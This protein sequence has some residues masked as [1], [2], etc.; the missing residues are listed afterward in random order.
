[1]YRVLQK[2]YEA[3][4]GEKFVIAVGDCA[5]NGGMFKDSYYTLGGVDKVLKVDLR[6]PGCPPSPITII[7]HLLTFLRP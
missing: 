5:V 2:T 1:M 4:P 6:I 7:R 3:M